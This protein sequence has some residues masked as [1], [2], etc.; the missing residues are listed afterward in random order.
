MSK[1]TNLDAE[2]KQ[3]C[4]YWKKAL[5]DAVCREE[6]TYDSTRRTRDLEVEVR[7]K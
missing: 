7:Q 3:T 1:P 4:F 2:A 5:D 6:N